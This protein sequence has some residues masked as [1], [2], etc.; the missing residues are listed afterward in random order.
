VLD[1]QGASANPLGIILHS[2]NEIVASANG[3][4][5]QTTHWVEVME[6]LGSKGSAIPIVMGSDAVMVAYLSSILSARR[7]G[8]SYKSMNVARGP[9]FRN[10]AFDASVFERFMTELDSLAKE[11][12]VITLKISPQE[13]SSNL[14]L[15]AYLTSH[16][17]RRMPDNTG[18]SLLHTQTY[19]LSLEGSEDVILSRMMKSTRNCIAKAGR[20]NHVQIEH[21]TDDEKVRLFHFPYSRTTPNPASLNFFE[22]VM[23]I[24]GRKGL[25]R[26]FLAKVGNDVAAASFYLMFGRKIFYVWAGSLRRYNKYAPGNLLHWRAIQWAKENGYSLYDFHGA[27]VDENDWPKLPEKMVST[28]KFK[29][30]FG[31]M[32]VK[33]IGEYHKAYSR[34][35][36]PAGLRFLHECARLVRLAHENRNSV[37]SRRRAYMPNLP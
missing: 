18:T 37:L 36:S 12:G 28:A 6:A 17:F 29:R 30:G 33:Y 3:H 21:G 15:H 25:A 11:H 4:I 9:V 34:L 5:F 31:G 20:E 27:P 14:A 24:L 2:W 7:I 1:L 32:P 26:V 16:G 8:F 19:I 13:L 10:G 35:G 23:A 22:T